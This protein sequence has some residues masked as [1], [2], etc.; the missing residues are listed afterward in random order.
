L[1]RT[2]LAKDLQQEF[3]FMIALFMAGGTGTRLWPLSRRNNPKQLH[4]LVGRKSLMTQTVE[5]IAPQI[6]PEDIWIVTNE[7]YAARIARHSPK[8]PKQQIITEP[9]P[10]GT[11]LAVGLGAIHIARQNPDAIILVGWADSYIGREQEF[12]NALKKAELLAPDVDGIIFGVPPTFPA[13]GYGYIEAGKSLGDGEGVFEIA[14]FEEKPDEIRARQ[15]F[16]SN[17]HFWNPGISVWAVSN[18]LKLMRRYKPDHFDAL[19]YVSEAIGTDKVAARMQDAFKNLDGMAI[20]HAIFEKATRLA[21]IQVDLEW[22]DIGSWSAI[23]DIQ[24]KGN[25]NVTRGSVVSIDTDKCLIYAQ[26]RL[27]ATL[28]VSDLV[29]VETADAILIA[30][31]NDSERLKELH[32]RVEAF[33]G[34]KYL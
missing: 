8:V 32:A 14:R 2:F 33:G 5:R 20:D 21:T 12:R 16:E 23:Y 30:H 29:I 4:K 26:K 15:F 11:N 31:K 24:S 1:N 28:G 9:F 34:M 10:L 3:I 18:L 6:K 17:A 22:S 7:S 25:D 19:Q 13:T 27:V